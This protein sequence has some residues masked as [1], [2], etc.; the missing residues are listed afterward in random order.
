MGALGTKYSTRVS[1]NKNE[2]PGPP[3]LLEVFFI[4]NALVST[5][6]MIVQGVDIFSWIM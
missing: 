5:L 1:M 3:E 6:G 2:P 4:V